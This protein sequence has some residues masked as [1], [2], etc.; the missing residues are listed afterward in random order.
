M[1]EK[2]FGQIYLIRNDVT[3]KKYVGQT[4]RCDIRRRWREHIREARRGCPFPLH[5]AI[6]KYGIHNFT[7]SPLDCGPITNQAELDAAEVG[8]IAR[9]GTAVR[10]YNLTYGGQ[11]AK[12]FTQQAIDTRKRILAY[13][14]EKAHRSAVMR[15]VWKNPEHRAN[16]IAAF[17]RPDVKAR[18]RAALN[19]PDVKA[20]RVASAR[21]TYAR[22]EIREKVR[23][24]ILANYAKPGVREKYSSIQRAIWARPKKRA[25]LRAAA[26]KMYAE[27]PEVKI[28]RGKS[29]KACWQTPEYRAK[30]LAAQNAGRAIRKKARLLGMLPF[31]VKWLLLYNPSLA[32]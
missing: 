21:A 32:D 31:P 12:K 11:S 26:N 13:P 7:I 14:Y 3:G 10:G 28:K 15:K 30:T 5:C 18:H 27:K 17:S 2:P 16:Y 1:P 24:A 23:A 9:L 20:R 22:P 19:R 6:R 4:R 29:S 8:A 25:Q